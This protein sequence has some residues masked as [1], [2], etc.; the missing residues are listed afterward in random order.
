MKKI[1]RVEAALRGDGVDRPPYAF[2]THLPG[3]DLDP[4]ALARATADFA[5]R[6]DLDFIKSMPNGL[7]CVEDWGAA[8]DYSEIARG[9][10]AKVTRPA[11][12]TANDWKTL[13][14]IDVTRGAYGRELSHLAQLA[15][16]V[17]PDVPV[18]AT[19][20]SPLTV[21]AKLSNGAHL[22]HLE[23]DPSALAQ[24]LAVITEVTAAFAQA[25]IRAGCAGVFFAV[26]DASPSKLS[27][28]A[29]R[30]NG[31]PFDRQVLQ[32]AKDA[33]GWFTVIHMHGDDV[34]FDLLADY[35]VA[36]LNWHIGETPP[37]IADYRAAGGTRPI[38]GG[39]QRGAITRRD[40]AGV[41]ADVERTLR[42]SGGRGIL[43]APACVIRHPVDD[44]ILADAIAMIKAQSH[45]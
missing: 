32:S 29:Y 9:G 22:A 16:R 24:G 45:A 8:T 41:R 7:Y 20:F 35:D 42:E 34:M 15:R 13:A 10:V 12:D 14:R 19:V 28:A 25:A 43:I 38:V 37:S 18:L 11:V 40:A 44:G 6:H 5:A 36:A 1:D 26:Q 27:E 21:A 33:G 30:A 23:T 17:G 39:L 2:W 4:E 31:E 3:I